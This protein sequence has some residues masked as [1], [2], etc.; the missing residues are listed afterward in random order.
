MQCVS[1]QIIDD[2]GDESLEFFGSLSSRDD[3]IPSNVRL[4]P[5]RAIA[6]IINKNCT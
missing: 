6:T 3:I 5:R 2:G 4:E 1:I